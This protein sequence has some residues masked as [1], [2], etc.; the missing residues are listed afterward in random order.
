MAA[1]SL[2]V[3]LEN[4]AD[5]KLVWS[6]CIETHC[7]LPP[8]STTGDQLRR[9]IFS[10]LDYLIGSRPTAVDLSNAV[11]MLKQ[12][13]AVVTTSSVTLDSAIA[14]D[15]I[16]KAYVEG[17][18]KILDDDLTTNLAI[19]RY[20]AEYLR[21]QQMPVETSVAESDGLRYFTTSPPGT[22]GAPDRTYRKLSV[23]THCNT[24]YAKS[25]S[26]ICF[27]HLLYPRG[28]LT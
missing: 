11:R 12:I 28:I 9:Y 23:L 2:A 24:G 18:E 21:R 7:S 27:A 10:Q 15:N 5:G 6:R 22:Q 13:T 4:K 1:L 3:E 14:C 17:A 8:A 20:G 25:N 16:R 26:I 19:G